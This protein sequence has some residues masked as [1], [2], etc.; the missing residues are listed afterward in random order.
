MKTHSFEIKGHQYT[1]TPHDGIEGQSIFFELLAM[2]VEPLL[3]IMSSAQSEDA[4]QMAAISAASGDVSNALRRLA[5]RPELFR[6]LFK[7]TTRDGLPLSGEGAFRLAYAANW[8]EQ[9]MA[10]KH[11]IEINGFVDFIKDLLTSNDTK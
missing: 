11:I 1:C 8:G 3:K 9:L 5:E 10:A 6:S 7:Y 4:R 2:G